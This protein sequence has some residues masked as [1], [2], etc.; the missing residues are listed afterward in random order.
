M[1][2]D[3]HSV[4]RFADR[5]MGKRKGGPSALEQRLWSAA[6]NAP[7][8]NKLITANKAE[9]PYLLRT[10]MTPDR[11]ELQQTLYGLGVKNELALKAMCLAR[12]YL[13]Y[14][15]RGDEDREVHN[16]PWQR[17]ISLILTGGY[18]E[19]RWLPVL[20]EFEVRH[21]VPGKLN[22]IRRNDF[23]RVELYADQGC[24]TLFLS[25]GRVMESNGRDW[26]FL[27]TDTNELIPWGSWVQN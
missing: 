4:A 14:F 16:H 1:S 11:K 21:L 5:E 24:W 12:P 9:D 3:R 17:S 27:N 2:I 22:Y 26:S 20:R 19:Y 8:G 25:M 10:Y 15:F 7:Y 13:H 6:I 23:H 18:K